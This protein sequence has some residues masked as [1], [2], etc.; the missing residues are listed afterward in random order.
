MR[1][2][3]RFLCGLMR[4]LLSLRYR[5]KVKGIEK[6]TSDLLPHSGG[7]LFLA[8]HPAEIDP[9][10]LIAY[11]WPSF[12]PRPV[13]V[14][15]LFKQ[16]IVGYLLRKAGALAVP[17]FD[18]SSNSYKRKLM[19]KTY[20]RM[21]EAIESKENLLIY[22]AGLLKLGPE[23]LLG[24]ASGVHTIL[25]RAPTS[26]IVLVRTTGLWGSSF[27]KAFT[28]KTPHLQRAFLNGLK[29]LL[30]NGIFFAPRR[31][32]I[33]ELEVAGSD[34]P[35]KGERLEVNRYLENWYNAYGPEPLNHVSFSRFKDV[36]PEVAAQEEQEELAL[37]CV[38]EELKR[39]VVAEI[40]KLSRVPL[41]Q[42][43]MQS[44]LAR[45]LGMDSLDSAQLAM[46]IK[47]NFGIN[48]IHASDLTTVASVVGF[49]A[50]LKK[51]QDQTQ[52]EANGKSLWDKEDGRPEA[53]YP[54]GKTIP[55]LFLQTCAR[56]GKRTA[57]TDQVSHV[58][59][60]RRLKQAVLLLAT[61]IKK[62]EGKHVG[63]MMPASV[64]V[65]ALVLATLF[66]RKVPVMVNW[67]L[68]ERNINSVAQQSGIKATLSS[69]RFIDRLDNVDLGV[70]D[71][72]IFLMEE[73]TK[74]FTLKDKL[75]AFFLSLRKMSSILAAC[76]LDSLSEEECAVILFTSGT[77]S[78]PKGVP[79]THKNIISNQRGAFDLVKIDAHD[80]LL[81]AL[82]PFHSFGFSVTGLFP[83]LAGIRAAY[84]P[85]PT[86][87][88]RIAE[89]IERWQASLLCLAPTFL[90]NLARVATKEQLTSLR[91]IVSGAEKLADELYERFSQLNEQVVLLE[92][93][94]ITEC[95]PILTL[96]LPELPHH[97]VGAP[98]PG[99]ELKIVHEETLTPLAEGELGLILA[100]GPNVFHGYLDP[101]LA[102]PFVELEGKKWYLTGDLGYIKDGRFLILCGRLKRFVKIGGEMVSLTAIE[103]VLAQAGA[104]RGWS[105]D[106]ETPSL[107]VC[108]LELEGKKS[109][110]H[111]FTT[112]D[113]SIDEVN[114]LL[115]Q[116]KMSNIIKI[117]SVKK[118]SHIP[119]LGTG[120]I[121]YRKLSAK[122]N[123]KVPESQT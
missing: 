17:N 26:N 46:Q 25:E 95:A 65:N 92:G 88:R 64:A 100:R 1:F 76:G 106:G 82:P 118:L 108:A 21:R 79:L 34:F 122:L 49:A 59:S 54:E 73:V 40:A 6:I 66:A 115:R 102:S 72:Q 111:L 81:G 63:I 84:A 16:R 99:I 85:N 29:V 19:D 107:A 119:L 14:D 20:Q 78:Y 56:M 71:E 112:V 23:E 30:K 123:T 37:D 62:I 97:G 31:S 55:E 42:I 117:R 116:A 11:L 45:D 13:A 51:G 101:H 3:E 60:Y 58:V 8:N 86:D 98:L 80:V 93:Y 47:E 2:G 15:Y 22:P 74:T 5:V 61:Y 105:F 87:G 50:R 33:I 94:G 91:L 18:A 39:Q 27:S 38:P 75:K 69:W 4:W 96:N 24:G 10:I 103:D 89:A 90:K 36:Y 109:E 41:S 104:S 68:G 43:T 52:I 9:L 121:D 83:L 32:V 67:T 113:T 53:R 48:A 114:A 77:E 28:G 57:C 7:I 44:H 110:M 35:W 120:K 12:A 70:L